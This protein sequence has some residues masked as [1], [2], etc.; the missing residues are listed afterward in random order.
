MKIY[1]NGDSHS[2]A[3]EAACAHAFAEDD[4]LLHHMGRA[5]HPANL[6]VSY[7]KCLADMLKAVHHTDAESAS[8]N[9]RILRTTMA[10]TE[11]NQ[12]WLSD[13]IMII[14][15]STWERQEWVLD[16][17]TYQITASG[18]DDVPEQHRERYRQWILDLDWDQCVR[19]QHQII[20]DMHQHLNNLGARHVFFNGN[21][22]FSRIPPDLRKDWGHSYIMPYDTNGTFHSMLQENRFETVS[23]QSW[24]YGADA[25]AW[26]ARFLRQYLVANK[27]I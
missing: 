15:W 6:A 17:C 5:P 20:W 3:A 18:T 10:W 12:R 14:Q 23:P 19:Q 26:W 24:H 8:S 25:H 1:I 27:L 16:G 4:G 9:A 7:G 22:D 21:N 11:A 13:T 2:A